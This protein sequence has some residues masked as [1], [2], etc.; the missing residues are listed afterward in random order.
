MPV[1]LAP[2]DGD[3]GRSEQGYHAEQRRAQP[4]PV[5]R[6]HHPLHLSSAAAVLLS[7]PLPIVGEY[8]KLPRQEQRRVAQPGKRKA[9]VPAR[10]A[11]P[12]VVQQV[13]LLFGAD[14]PVD[15][16]VL[17]GPGPGLAAGEQV[18]PRPADGVLDHVGEERRQHQADGQAEDGD[19]VLV[20]R[21]ARGEVGGHHDGQRHRGRVDDVH[22]HGY[23]LVLG[24]REGDG[25]VADG[26]HAMEGLYE[27][28]ELFS[29]RCGVA[30]S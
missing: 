16:A 7:I 19:V 18:W 28:D 20:G 4:P 24:V 25:Q 23:T 22:E 21:G 29:G 8:P 17:R 14:G 10:K 3:H 6:R 9:R 15:E 11:P 26:E 5:R 1:V 12:P 13:V 27:E 30:E 2:A